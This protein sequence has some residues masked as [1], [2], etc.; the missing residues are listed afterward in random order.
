MNA[1]R[2]FLKRSGALVVSFTLAGRAW[3]QEGGGSG[4]PAL[5][6]LEKSPY[7]DAWI[8]IDAASRVTVFTG[9]AELGQG[10]K[11][12][13]TQVAAEE[14]DVAFERV[15]LVTADT[16]ATPNEGFTAGSNSMKDSATAIRNAAAQVRELLL[17]KAATRLNV[18]ADSLRVEDG[19]IHS[20]EGR[21]VTYGDLVAG[22]ELH[23]EAKPASRFKDPKQYRLV[24]KSIPRVDIPGKVTGAVAYVHDLRLPGM[25][26][27]RVVRPPSYGAVLE[28]VDT[29]AAERSAPGVKVVRD[30]NFLAV[31]APREYAAVRAMRRLAGA[32]KWRETLESSSRVVDVLML[33]LPCGRT[34]GESAS[35]PRCPSAGTGRS[36]PGQVH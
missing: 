2:D 28:S 3:P 29:V 13:I 25:L 36:A 30:G 9:K 11:T 21:R 10:I 7:L 16:A 5:G 17:A 22:E 19:T 27:A 12:A 15:S 4:S 32:A 14:L 6:S 20:R 24:S 33:L 35:D 18:A 1:R 23:V 26:H 31:V 34:I 8:R